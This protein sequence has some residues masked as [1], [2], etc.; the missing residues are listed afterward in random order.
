MTIKIKNLGLLSRFNSIDILQTKHYLKLYNKT[1]INKFSSHNKWLH[2]EVK[3]MH[4]FP[5]PM[6]T[7]HNYKRKIET[8]EPL[9]EKELKQ[10]EKEM[11]FGYRQEIGELIY[12]MVT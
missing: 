10:Y 7:E 5:L 12:A 6:N 1:Y 2:E 4:E 8:S 9:T 3:Q 11:G